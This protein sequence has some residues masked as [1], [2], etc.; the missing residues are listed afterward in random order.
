[1]TIPRIASD[2]R[3]IIGHNGQYRRS[4]RKGV[5]A[6]F[7][8]DTLTSLLRLSRR[9]LSFMVEPVDAGW[10]WSARWPAAK[11]TMNSWS[12]Q[13]EPIDGNIHQ[14]YRDSARHYHL[15]LRT[16]SHVEGGHHH[17]VAHLNQSVTNPFLIINKCRQFDKI[18]HLYLWRTQ[19]AMQT[20][21]ALTKYW[22]SSTTNVFVG[23][24]RVKSNRLL[25]AQVRHWLAVGANGVANERACWKSLVSQQQAHSSFKPEGKAY[26]LNRH[27]HQ[28]IRRAIVAAWLVKQKIHVH[29][30]QLS[31]QW[32]NLRHRR[33]R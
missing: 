31:P 30:N 7:A 21:T 4:Q 3:I 6:S 15:M 23:A 9:C 24:I 22:L 13:P 11:R 19:T 29:H 18:N 17:S 16:A 14:E 1:M 10:G 12:D 2:I 25:V 26:Y 27:E 28:P 8:V 20:W 5:Y 33:T 32:I